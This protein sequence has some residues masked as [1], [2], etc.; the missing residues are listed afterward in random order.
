VPEWNTDT[1]TYNPLVESAALDIHA[2]IIQCNNRHYG[3]SRIRAPY[4]VRWKRD[5]LR[6]KGGSHDYCITGEIEILALRK[7]Q[8]SHRSTS[9]PF[10]PVPDGF[11]DAM[12][13]NR[14][15]LPEGKST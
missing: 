6:V 15:V 2:F 13:Q 4:K 8:S 5:L 11:L 3:D 1:E 10:K 12:D 7:F 14:K 9:V